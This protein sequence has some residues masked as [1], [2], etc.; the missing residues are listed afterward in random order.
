MVLICSNYL[1]D[2]FTIIVDLVSDV[3]LE[4][5]VSRELENKG[6]KANIKI[7]VCREFSWQQTLGL[8]LIH[9]GKT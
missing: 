1:R 7:W 8:R 4:R 2:V 6:L 3:N 9:L 5:D